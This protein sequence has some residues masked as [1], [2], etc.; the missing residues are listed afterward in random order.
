MCTISCVMRYLPLRFNVWISVSFSAFQNGTA[1]AFVLLA[2]ARLRNL[3]RQSHHSIDLFEVVAVLNVRLTKLVAFISEGKT[4][5]SRQQY[6]SR[7]S[8]W[9]RAR[10]C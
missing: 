5:M 9:P 4:R 6:L 1:V 3:R 7:K 8:R 2:R 10:C